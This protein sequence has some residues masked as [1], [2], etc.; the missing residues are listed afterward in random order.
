MKGEETDF[1][2]TVSITWAEDMWSMKASS[3]S[4]IT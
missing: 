4:V 1:S 3:R 2:D